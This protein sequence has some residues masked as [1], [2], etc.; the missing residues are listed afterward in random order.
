MNG[1]TKFLLGSMGVVGAF[2]V[3]AI[4]NALGIPVWQILGITVVMVFLF[5]ILWISKGWFRMVVIVVCVILMLGSAWVEISKD[6]ANAPSPVVIENN[7]TYVEAPEDIEDP[8]LREYET[9]KFGINQDWVA[10]TFTGTYQLLAFGFGLTQLID[11]LLRRSKLNLAIPLEVVMFLLGAF[12]ILKAIMPTGMTDYD[13]VQA[14]NSAVWWGFAGPFVW[15]AVMQFVVWVHS[16][17][18]DAS[19][20]TIRVGGIG[21][22]IGVGLAIFA[23]PLVGGLF[24]LFDYDFFRTVAMSQDMTSSAITM[25]RWMELY[26]IGKFTGMFVPV[27]ARQVAQWFWAMVVGRFFF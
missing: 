25:E 12:I 19:T 27:I 7:T 11:L 26:L 13:T 3:M 20:A 16:R 14:E 17:T 5:L 22:F 23:Y 4:L 9:K 10:N 15:S 18:E 1:D 8:E 6:V 2:A 21:V 24:S